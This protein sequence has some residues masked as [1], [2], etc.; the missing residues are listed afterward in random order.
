M[1]KI[2]TIFSLILFGVLSAQQQAV[3]ISKDHSHRPNDKSILDIKAPGSNATTAPP[4][5]VLLPR[6]SQSEINAINVST[7]PNGLLIF[8]K[9]TRCFNYYSTQRTKWESMCGTPTT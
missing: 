4:A 3:G 7:V 2:I 8:N 1:K 6:L 9:T 5:G